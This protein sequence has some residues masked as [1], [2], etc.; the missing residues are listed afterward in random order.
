ME[1]DEGS[2]SL[3]TPA[4]PG[5]A[6]RFFVYLYHLAAG[7]GATE[8]CEP[9]GL[10][11]PQVAHPEWYHWLPRAQKPKVSKELALVRLKF[12]KLILRLSKAI[13]REK[14]SLSLDGVI[15]T[16]PPKDATD[17]ANFCSYGD[18]H[19]WRKRGEAAHPDLAGDD[20]YPDQV[21]VSRAV[22]MWGGISEGGVAIVTFHE[23]KKIVTPEWVKV[24]NA[25]KLKNAIQSIS[26][27]KPRGPWQVLCDGE[28]FLWTG[29]S[30]AAC[31]A[32]GVSMW[33]VPPKSPD[34]NPIEKYWGWLRKQLR[35]KDLADMRAKRP[36]ISKLAYKARVRAIC[37]TQKA[38]HVA[39]KFAGDMRRVC[40][41]VIKKKGQ[42]S[43]S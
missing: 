15:L 1:G 19:M 25:G 20:P 37:D 11:H 40:K 35:L 36:V 12:A 18:T 7:I 24:V 8:R 42:R 30:E 21:P 26:P 34:L 16:L 27:V 10:H 4:A 38:K 14:L 31:A 23:Q 3:L 9:R 39:S 32:C 17:R 13:L 6:E 43:R 5:A 2:R 29:A 33:R 28:K 41:E 22:P